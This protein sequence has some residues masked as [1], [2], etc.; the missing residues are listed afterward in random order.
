[1]NLYDAERSP[2]ARTVASNLYESYGIGKTFLKNEM[3]HTKKQ[4]Q[5]LA[6]VDLTNLSRVGFRGMDTASYLNSFGFTLP[7][8][9]N[10]ALL[11]ADSSWVARLS[12]TEY[13]LLGSFNDFGERISQLENGW[14]M[15]ERANYLLPR[16]DSHGWL[17]LT[18]SAAVAVMAKLCAVDLSP[19][20]FQIGQIAQTSIAR[21]NGIVINVS[22]QD[23]VKFTILCDRAAVLYLWGVLL[24]AMDEFAG[25]VVGIESLL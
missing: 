14:S 8:Q 9:S 24:D 13:L 10:A 6:I 17:Q 7:E 3:V 4:I 19:E 11:Q 16:Q 2:I 1:M 23:S 22:D 5:H 21:T 25:K 18:G 12:A 20:V 15:D